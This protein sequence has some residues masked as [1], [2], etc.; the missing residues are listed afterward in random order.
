MCFFFPLFRDAGDAH[1]GRPLKRFCFSLIFDR[2]G[3]TFCCI[4][5]Q[6]H[7][8]LILFRGRRKEEGRI[9]RTKILFINSVDKE[10]L[11]LERFK[12]CGLPF[13]LFI[14]GTLHQNFS[15]IESIECSIY[16]I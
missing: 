16:E 13:F 4:G 7:D 14:A 12:R 8:P 2:L 1:G 15:G 3:G 11:F 6:G 10:L 9:K 5:G